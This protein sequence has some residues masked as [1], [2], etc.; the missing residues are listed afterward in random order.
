M[1]KV[2]TDLDE[3]EQGLISK[4]VDDNKVGGIADY[5]DAYQKLQQDL[6]QLGKWAVEWQMVIYADKCEVFSFVKSNQGRNFTVNGRD[7]QSVV[8]QRHGGAAVE[9]LPH[10]AGDLGLFLTAGSC[11]SK[12]CKFFP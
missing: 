6:D 9:S 12:V 11:Q 4:F 1:S 7:L 2:T 8:G 5:K 3:S 10:S